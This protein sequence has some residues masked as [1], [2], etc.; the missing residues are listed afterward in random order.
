MLPEV[1]SSRLVDDVELSA[2]QDAG[3]AWMTLVGESL[4]LLGLSC[5]SKWPWKLFVA[6]AK[7]TGVSSSPGLSGLISP[8]LLS[9]SG[10]IRVAKFLGE[11]T[12]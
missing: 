3:C 10:G 11:L 12:P 9:L 7:G 4:H 2:I 5:G 8:V 6:R 1:N